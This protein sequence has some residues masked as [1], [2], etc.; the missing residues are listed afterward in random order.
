MRTRTDGLHFPH[1][2]PINPNH[3]GMSPTIQFTQDIG[4]LD[5]IGGQGHQGFDEDIHLLAGRLPEI[6]VLLPGLVS[7]P[8]NFTIEG[9]PTLGSVASN[10]SSDGGVAC[11]RSQTHHTAPIGE[12][13]PNIGWAW[14]HFLIF[15]P[16]P[17][18]HGSLRPSFRRPG[19]AGTVVMLVDL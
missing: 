18:G 3:I 4:P 1:Q 13:R 10:S 16:D 17:L 14:R 19:T 7:T 8:S 15:I 6:H 9:R 2:P 12:S 11:H 5:L